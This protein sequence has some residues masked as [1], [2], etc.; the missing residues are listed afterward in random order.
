MKVLIINFNRLTLP[1][2]MAEWIASKGCEPVFIDNNSDYQPLL[3][4]YENCPFKVVRL[5]DNYGHKVLWN[6]DLTLLHELI[7]SDRYIV[8]DPDLDL[9]G[10]PDDFADIMHL[11]L[12][13][14]KI[15][16][17]CGLSL[18]INDLPDTREGRLVRNKFEKK[19]WT[20]PLDDIFFLADTD[21]T[22]AMYREG[23]R[24]YSY[25]AIRINRPYTAR[26]IPWYYDRLRD[27]PEDEQ[28]YF[29][30]ATRSSSG[31]KRLRK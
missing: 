30:N 27:L 12:D 29:K 13:K 21:T 11:G 28:Y 7:G 25:S 5:K 10:V 24:H 2:N 26:H 3:K 17:K 14:Y 18:E 31:K 4:Y 1:K 22:F 20:N 6:P 23:V 19:Y 9:S 8:T 15:Y 16:D